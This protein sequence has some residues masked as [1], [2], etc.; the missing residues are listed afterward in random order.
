MLRFSGMAE[1]AKTSLVSPEEY[2]AGEEHADTRHE[3]VAGAVYAMAG[4]RNRHNTVKGNVFASFHA[5]LRGKPCRP[6]DS[7]TKV[8]LRLP[9]QVR[10]YYPDALITCHP[11]PPG[12]TFQDRP[13]VVVEVLSAS[14]RR[15]DEGE[16]REGYL[17]LPSLEAYLLVESE[18]A[19]IVC[20]RRVAAGF[21]REVYEGMSAEVALPDVG[22]VLRLADVYEGAEGVDEGALPEHPRRCGGAATHRAIP[23]KHRSSQSCG[24]QTL[25]F[26]ARTQASASYTR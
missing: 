19:S 11:N 16:K 22:V 14:T 1:P 3:Y 10:F 26:V 21:V 13:I 4:G 18:R 23:T 12:D 8:R 9:D 17:A 15:T 6:F 5:Q 24:S 20:L 25:R 2:L 7:D